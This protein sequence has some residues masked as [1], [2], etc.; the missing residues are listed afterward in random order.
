[1]GGGCSVAWPG[2]NG[3]SAWLSMP[4]I[5][6]L[7]AGRA[8]CPDDL[9]EG[10][11][12]VAAPARRVAGGDEG[13][14]QP[15]D[16]VPADPCVRSGAAAQPVGAVQDEG[17]QARLAVEVLGAG[18]VGVRDLERPVREHGRV[19]SVA[20][21]VDTT[22]GEHAPGDDARRRVRGGGGCQ[23]LEVL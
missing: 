21:V 5:V 1:M 9:L 4:A 10:H 8:L 6:A 3:P 20:W 11:G 23:D 14:V 12:L 17:A 19:H 2:S 22:G 18:A 15:V 16:P 7:Q 13:D